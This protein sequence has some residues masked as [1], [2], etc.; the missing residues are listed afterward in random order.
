[1]VVS[2]RENSMRVFAVSG[3][4]DTGKTTL[5]EHIVRELASQGY[6]IITVKSSQHAPREGEGTDT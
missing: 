6:S 1:M 2:Q 4:S 3:F 5:V